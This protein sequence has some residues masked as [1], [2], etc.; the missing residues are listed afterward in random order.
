MVYASVEI[1]KARAKELGWQIT[2]DAWQTNDTYE[3]HLTGGRRGEFPVMF[4]VIYKRSPNTG[5]WVFGRVEEISYE[6]VNLWTRRN[7]HELLELW[8]PKSE[9]K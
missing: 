4:R 8:K 9:D 3:V 7:L 6:I 2:Y 1:D 5:A